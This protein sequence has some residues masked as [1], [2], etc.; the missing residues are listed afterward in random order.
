HGEEIALSHVA[1]T[2]PPVKVGAILLTGNFVTR[3]DVILGE[4]PL[5]TGSPFDVKKLLEGQAN[6]RSLGLFDSVSIE[7]V[8]LD[9]GARLEE[10]SSAAL[11]ISVDEGDYYYFDISAGIQGRDLTDKTRR[12]LLAVAD[13]EYNN[14][15]FF[16]RAQRLQPR[17]LVAIDMLQMSELTYGLVSRS[18]EREEIASR[19]DLLTGIEL[20]YSHP[21]FLKQSLGVDALLLTIAPYALLDLIGVSINN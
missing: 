16:G 3:S 9:E 19:F 20:V 18:L 12:K 4:L 8:G 10:E 11:V 17:A 5:E 13:I 21:R 14:R 15:N 7:A 6:L 2:G 1:S